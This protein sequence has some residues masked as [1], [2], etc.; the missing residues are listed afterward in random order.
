MP[1]TWPFTVDIEQKA[2][3]GDIAI[4]HQLVIQR[5]QPDRDYDIG[6][7]RFTPRLAIHADLDGVAASEG[8]AGHHAHA[9]LS[10]IQDRVFAIHLQPH[11]PEIAYE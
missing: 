1:E 7:V 9:I 5:V 4:R 2:I 6:D 10:H 3:T 11:R 8:G